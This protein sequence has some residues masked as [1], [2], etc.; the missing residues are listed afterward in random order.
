MESESPKDASQKQL[1]NLISD[2]FNN[3]LNRFKLI[4]VILFLVTI[5]SIFLLYGLVSRNARLFAVEYVNQELD[6]RQKSFEVL[7]TLVSE[8]QSLVALSSNKGTRERLTV[9]EN[10]IM[11]LSK[12]MEQ[13]RKQ[14]INAN[15]NLRKITLLL[16]ESLTHHD[17]ENS[18]E[19]SS[20]ILSSLK[21]YALLE[22]AT[23]STKVKKNP[24][25]PEKWEK[26]TVSVKF[27]SSEGGG[28]AFQFWDKNKK[29]TPMIL[30]EHLFIHVTGI[31]DGSKVIVDIEFN[32]DIEQNGVSM[33]INDEMVYD[34]FKIKLTRITNEYAI[35]NIARNL[36]R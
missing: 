2:K 12:T 34:Y 5:G 16:D 23:I 17:K 32:Y 6:Q 8:L 1:E 33:A 21:N 10:D 29:V 19:T 31:I 24:Q 15:E 26:A 30:E 3:S 20:E 28:S 22:E 14:A 13:Y 35:F 4:I 27:D 18:K 11:V 7:Q 9:L 36:R 25:L